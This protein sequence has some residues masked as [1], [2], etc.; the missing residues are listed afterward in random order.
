[1]SF[2]KKIWFVFINILGWVLG[3]FL[4]VY[5][6]TM[7]LTDPVIGLMFIGFGL[8]CTP[9]VYSKIKQSNISSKQVV[10]FV[11]VIIFGGVILN[12][13]FTEPSIAPPVTKP[14]EN[15]TRDA[16]QKAEPRAKT[17]EPKVI[18]KPEKFIDKGQWHVRYDRS[19]IDDSKSVYLILEAKN[20][21]RN[22]FG[23]WTT[24][25]LHIRCQENKTDLIVNFDTFLGIDETRVLHRMGKEK[26][27]TRNWSIASNH[28]AVF[29]PQPIGF[30]R[31]MMKHDNFLVQTTPHSSNTVTTEF[32]THGLSDAIKPLQNVCGWR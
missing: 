5:G 1:M 31:Q 30:I 28:L 10:G 16:V 12:S 32:D 4:M 25:S 2:I 14:T 19:R 15:I 18:A 9:Y 3:L 22:D 20:S 24:P 7:M 23:K 26:A 6:V 17:D 8:V 29:A 21:F 13:L 27:K 11:V